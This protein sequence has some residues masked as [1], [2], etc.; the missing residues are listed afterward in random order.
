MEVRFGPITNPVMANAAARIRRGREEAR[1]Q[2]LWRAGD[3]PLD[4][5]V[6][7]MKYTNVPRQVLADET[8]DVLHILASGRAEFLRRLDTRI[9]KTVRELNNKYTTRA[10]EP[11]KKWRLADIGKHLRDGGLGKVHTRA[12]LNNWI[13]RSE[14]FIVHGGARSQAA[15]RRFRREREREAH[16]EA[17]ASTA[18]ANEYETLQVRDAVAAVVNQLKQLP[19][20]IDDD[21]DE[22]QW[23]IELML[24][25]VNEC[26]TSNVAISEGTLAELR[27]SIDELWTE[28]SDNAALAPLIMKLGELLAPRRS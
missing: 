13:G 12:G 19:S 5:A 20:R 17:I 10:K 16:A 7:A 1:D 21:G 28:L 15:A 25:T 23:W 18:P 14:N 11:G 6:Y 27:F 22:E 2:D 9:V 4:M 24:P 3:D 26:L 8:P